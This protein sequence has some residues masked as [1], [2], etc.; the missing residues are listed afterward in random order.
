MIIEIKGVI[1]PDNEKW[2]Y[3]LFG[4]QAISPSVIAEQLT[5]ANGEDITVL[6]NSDGGEI[7]AGSEIYEMFRTYQGNLTI[8]VV[9]LAA[10]AASV[11]A[12]ARQSEIAPTG[13][14]MIHN[15]YGGAEGDYHAMDKTSEVLKKANKAQT[16]A[17]ALKTGKPMDELLRLMDE[18]TWITADE[19]VELGFIDSISKAV[20]NKAY[21]LAAA[22]Y[23][24]G[25]LP[26]EVIH[27]YQNQKAARKAQ[28]SLEL[29]N[30]KNSRR[31]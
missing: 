6:I 24:S 13:M 31:S 18:E 12:C 25:L 14:L 20:D 7:F 27:K 16:N 11:V 28:A 2:I 10:S 5:S 29:L 1:V 23:D 3:D 30:L 19:A 15:V 9:G 8:K 17:Y 4:M 22:R 21:K 26:R